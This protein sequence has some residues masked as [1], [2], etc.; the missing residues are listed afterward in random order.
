MN[1]ID[2][3]DLMI[4]QRAIAKDRGD[5]ATRQWK[6]K[7]NNTYTMNKKRHRAALRQWPQRKR[8]GAVSGKVALSFDFAIKKEW[9]AAIEAIA[10]YNV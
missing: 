6:E 8:Y 7:W 2:E 9:Q 4:R 10:M 5:E 3:E 1:V